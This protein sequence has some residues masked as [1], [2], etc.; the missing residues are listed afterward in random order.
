MIALSR[1]L[2]LKNGPS[3]FP[4]Y[5]RF[6][7]QMQTTHDNGEHSSLSETLR[8]L[9]ETKDHDGLAIS[10]LT[11]AV[12]DKGFGLVL[13][14]L[15]L[16]SALPVPAPG[17]STPFGIA[18]ALL[19]IQMIRGNHSVW[20]PQKVSKLRIKPSLAHKMLGA[21][22]AFLRKIEFLIRPRHRWIRTQ[23]GQAGLATVIIIMAC[24]MM[25]PIPLTNTLPAMVIF[26]IGI[27]LSEEDGLLALGAFA[28]GCVAVLFYA[29][30]IYIFLT[31]G[32]EAIEAI[33]DGIKSLLGMESPEV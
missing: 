22:S 27:G 24:L 31:Q 26:L 3:P 17:Y 8:Q 18:I 5:F 29:G 14:V 15:A 4:P 23:F 20:L 1:R 19:A 7:N 32:S 33:K 9:L 28:I 21:A 30:I 6:A 11:Q 13:M 12:G 10:N 2:R 25:L 16:P